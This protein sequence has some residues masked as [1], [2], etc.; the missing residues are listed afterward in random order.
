MHYAILNCTHSSSLNCSGHSHSGHSHSGGV[1]SAA[2]GVTVASSAS[3]TPLRVAL[4]AA[5]PSVLSPSALVGELESQLSATELNAKIRQSVAG[6]ETEHSA[7]Q[8][9]A[10]GQGS[11]DS[12]AVVGCCAASCDHA[13]TIAHAVRIRLRSAANEQWRRTPHFDRDAHVHVA[14]RLSPT[15]NATR[16]LCLCPLLSSGPGSVSIAF[17]PRR[18]SVRCFSLPTAALPFTSLTAHRVSV[19]ESSLAAASGR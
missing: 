10:E 16:R 1:H 8:R 5:A 7:L 11:A 18:A 6:T 19:L 9:S 15:D 12:P 13:K 2:T 3:A 4:V 17:S 14:V